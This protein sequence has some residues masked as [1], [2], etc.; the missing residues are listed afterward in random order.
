MARVWGVRVNGWQILITEKIEQWEIRSC[1][2]Y[3][4]GTRGNRV[5]DSGVRL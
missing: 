2:S 5:R 3:R 4:R 1:S